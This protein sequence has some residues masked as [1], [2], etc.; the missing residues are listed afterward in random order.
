LTPAQQVALET[1]ITSAASVLPDLL[2]PLLLVLLVAFLGTLIWFLRGQ[3]RQ[4]PEDN[5][6]KSTLQ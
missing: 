1:R 4:S 2:L 3:K 6:P 5:A